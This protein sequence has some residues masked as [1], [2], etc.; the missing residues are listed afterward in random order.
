MADEAQDSGLSEGTQRCG[1]CR[2]LSKKA[3]KEI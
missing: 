1:D 3:I 2:G